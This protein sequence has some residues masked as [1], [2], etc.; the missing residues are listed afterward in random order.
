MVSLGALLLVTMTTMV[1]T[2]GATFHSIEIVFIRCLVGFLLLAPMAFKAR[3]AGFLTRRPVMHFL[4]AATG[5]TAMFC[6]FWA[7]THMPLADATAIVFSRP[8]FMIALALVFLGEVVGWRRGLATAAGFMGIL[9]MTRPFTEGFDPVAL[10]AA[11]GA[12]FAAL[13]VVVIKILAPSEPV[14]TIMI[15]FTLWTTLIAAIPAAMVWRMPS[16]TEAGLL[17]AVGIFGVAGQTAMTQGFKLG[18]ATFVVPFD[19]LRLIFATLFGIALF[20]EVPTLVNIIGAAV[21]IVSSFYILKRGA[22]GDTA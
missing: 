5:I 15:H 16:L 13:V 21:I 11:T 19:Y 12:L 6:I 18:E 17:V 4:R 2:L 1:K 7:V 14:M 10:V 9:I 22:P 3:G 20:A 8:L